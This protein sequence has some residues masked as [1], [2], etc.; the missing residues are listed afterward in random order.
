MELALTITRPARPA[1]GAW[2]AKAERVLAEARDYAIAAS[3]APGPW[4]EHS[5]GQA[6][7]LAELGARLQELLNRLAFRL[8][9]WARGRRR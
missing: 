5:S 1:L 9:R 3:S 7:A 8:R 6:T 4:E 2:L